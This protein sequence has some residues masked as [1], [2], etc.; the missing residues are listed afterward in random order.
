MDVVLAPELRGKLQLGWIESEGHRVT[1]SPEGLIG[2]AARLG[3]E[4]RELLGGRTPAEIP[5]VV[6]ARLLWRAIGIDPTKNRPSSE[7]LLRR[8]LKGESL[9]RI[10]SL[11]DAANLASARFLLPVGLYDAARFLGL[12]VQV[13]LGRP[14]E[15]Y[16]GIGAGPINVEGKICLADDAGPFGNPTADSARTKVTEATTRSAFALFAPASFEEGRVR[17]VLEGMGEELLR[18]SG[19]SVK[20]L[21]VVSGG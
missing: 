2:E 13:R 19:G 16:P 20:E 9:P 17:K 4:L 15:S 11:V 5:G 10:N 6:E 14:G 18:W 8:L 12:Q 3:E 7:K 21:R 1:P